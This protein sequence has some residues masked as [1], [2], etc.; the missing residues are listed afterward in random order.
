MDQLRTAA[1]F[2]VPLL[3]EPLVSRRRLLD[4]LEREIP[5]H[6]LAVLSAATGYGKTTLLAQWARMSRCEVVWLS[7]DADD[8]G[9][10]QLFRSLTVA[11]EHVRPGVATSPLALLAGSLGPDRGLL[12]SAFIEEAAATPGH[13]AFVLDDAHLLSDSDLVEVLGSVIDQLPATVHLVLAGRG[14]PALPLARYRARRQLLELD[15]NDLQFD[16]E[17]TGA[18]L[19]E[20]AGMD[21]P[22]DEVQS[23]H[24][25][26]EGWPAGIHLTS[27]ALGRHPDLPRPV[28]VGGRQR[29]ISDYLREEVLAGLSDDD[30]LFLL[31]TCILDELSASLCDAV[32]GRSNSRDILERLERMRAFV[33]ALDDDRQWYRFH[34]LFADVL[35]DELDRHGPGGRPDLHRRAGWWYVDRGLPDAAVHHAIQA[36]DVELVATIIERHAF[37]LLI[38]GEVRRVR[39]WLGQVPEGWLSADPVLGLAQAA[40]L[41]VTGAFDRCV[42]YLDALEARLRGSDRPDVAGRLAQVTAIRCFVACFENDLPMAE[43]YAERAL[44]ALPPDDLNFRPGIYGALGD[45]YRRNGLWREARASYLRM[46]DFA[47]APAARSQAVHLLGALAD[48]ELVQGHLRQAGEYWRMALAV[49]EEPEYRRSVPLPLAGWVYVRY[50]ELLCELH[51]LV[52]AWSY[53]ERGL[54][55]AELGGDSRALMAG[56]LAATRVRFAEGDLDGASAFLD[57]ARPLR[58]DVPLT[59]WTSRFDRMQV[60][61]WLAR[62]QLRSVASWVDQVEIPDPPDGDLVNLA[63]ARVLVATGDPSSIGRAQSILRSVLGQAEVDGRLHVQIESLAL[64]ALGWR[65][66]GDRVAAMTSLERAMSLAEPEG[67]VR[68]FADL[69][70]PMAHLLQESRARGVRPEYVAELLSAFGTARAEAPGVTVALPEPLTR[71]ERE[72]LELI[73][74]GLT[75]QEIAGQLSISAETVKKHTGNI[76]GKLGVRGRTQAIARARALRLLS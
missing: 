30:R 67:Y 42:T 70:T 32:T 40:S 10:D 2:R 16:I 48:L 54:E 71:R 6:K 68:L 49:V 9:V 39:R 45:T 51:R 14:M 41:L 76:Y 74:A 56:Y 28:S 73:A 64:Q 15:A 4:L 20:V 36:V 7:L 38:G 55:R 57:R 52:D 3:P 33:I 23:L 60:E 26:L 19:R 69:G 1:R 43:A 5:R 29:F 58:E 53:V 37:A 21:A 46:L 44:P 22:A 61:L 18:F 25:Q 34:R 31:Q 35:R 62:D 17:D 27:L 65:R 66:L 50:G 13:L 75:N 8:N 12:L 47:H 59:E 24:E 63:V 11:W 72:I